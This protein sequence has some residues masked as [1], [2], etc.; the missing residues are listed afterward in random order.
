MLKRRGKASGRGRA[1]ELTQHVPESVL[2]DESWI[3]LD[4]LRIESV[5]H[6]DLEILA[7]FD[8]E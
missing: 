7:R 3:V 1:L 8:T 2:G 6:Y 5:G 4:T